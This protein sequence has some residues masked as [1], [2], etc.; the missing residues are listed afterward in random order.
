MAKFIRQVVSFSSAA[1]AE[2]RISEFEEFNIVAVVGLDK[3]LV[4]IFEKE[5]TAGRP[6]KED[7][8]KGE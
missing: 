6:K 1:Q 3:R 2:S 7:S 5:K 8:N 4:F